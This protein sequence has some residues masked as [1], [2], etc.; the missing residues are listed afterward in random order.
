MKKT[1]YIVILMLLVGTSN[2]NAQLIDQ[3]NSQGRTSLKQLAQQLLEYRQANLEEA[4]KKANDAQLP[5]RTVGNDGSITELRGITTLGE[6]IYY[7]TDNLDAAKTV[8]TDKVWPGGGLG[9]SLTGDSVNVGEWDGGAVRLTH[10]ELTGRVTQVDGSVFLSDH[11][12]HVAGTIMASGVDS[13]AREM[14]Y[15]ANLNAYDWNFD[16]SEMTTGAANGMI[17]SNHSYGTITGWRYNST[18]TRWEWWG[19]TSVSHV[20]DY[21][22]GFYNFDAAAW[23]QIAYN[24]PGYLI[25]KSAGNDRGDGTTGLHYYANTSG[26]STAV[27]DDDGGIDGY[28]CI[29][30]NGV[31]KNILTIGAVNAIPGGYNSPSDVVMSSFRRMGT[32]R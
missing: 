8:G 29:S 23:D 15:T 21:K 26:T 2:T 11:A 32:N 19:D 22:F 18:L 27:R 24:A 13:T 5:L 28:D 6:L 3:G 31:A 17:L 9:L 12:T 1:T 4:K 20:E 30:T 16:N 7:T 14:A 10:H 25:V